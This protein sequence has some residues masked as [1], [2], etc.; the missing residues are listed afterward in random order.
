MTP[1]TREHAMLPW[2]VELQDDDPGPDQLAI[3]AQVTKESETYWAP[4]AV[5]DDEWRKDLVAGNAE[6]ICR[7]CNN[8]DSLVAALRLALEVMPADAMVYSEGTHGERVY[9]ADKLRDALKKLDEVPSE[10]VTDRQP[11]QG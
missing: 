10:Q 5:M 6:F 4:V 2:H 3:F 8:H 7:A 9:V 11:G 1:P